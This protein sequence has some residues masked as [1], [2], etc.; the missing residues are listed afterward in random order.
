MVL[1]LVIM[2][3]ND[4][5]VVDMYV[6]VYVYMYL[7]KCELYPYHIH[8]YLYRTYQAFLNPHIF[9]NKRKASSSLYRSLC[10]ILPLP[11]PSRSRVRVC[12][13]IYELMEGFSSLSSPVR[14]SPRPSAPL[15]PKKK[16]DVRFGGFAPLP[17]WWFITHTVTTRQ[18]KA[19][20]GKAS[21]LPAK[22][23]R[24]KIRNPPIRQCHD[25]KQP[26]YDGL[27]SRGL[28]CLFV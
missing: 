10:L 8:S 5:V 18:G 4:S 1:V 6:N 24:K 12:M 3:M 23:L 22:E 21:Y 16:K 25:A 11:S 20:Q 28:A 26:T 17:M 27:L 9:I 14:T 19:R 7:P 13:G 15:P 2:I